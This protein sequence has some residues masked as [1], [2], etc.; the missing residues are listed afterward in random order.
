MNNNVPL[1]EGLGRGLL[2]RLL[3]LLL[4][5]GWR[6][7]RV[8][9][10]VQVQVLIQTVLTQGRL[11]TRGGQQRLIVWSLSIKELGSNKGL[12][13]HLLIKVLPLQHPRG[14]HFVLVTAGL[15]QTL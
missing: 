11:V 4:L 7:V 10:L 14:A 8:E 1:K 5:V 13:G 15:I 9:G 3:L 6:G 12:I 2:E